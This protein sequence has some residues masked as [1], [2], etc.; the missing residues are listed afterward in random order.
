GRCGRRA[1]TIRFAPPSHLPWGLPVA[2]AKATGPLAGANLETVFLWARDFDR[3]KSFYRDT[4]GLSVEYENPH[5][6]ALH[7]GRCSIA[8]HL[9]WEAHPRSDSW[10]MEF[11]VE[12]IAG[13][14]ADLA[15]RGVR[16][17]P[18]RDERLGRTA[19]LRHPYG[20]VI[21]L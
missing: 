18:I 4:L 13:V 2:R 8:L 15:T 6:A 9:E 20:Q 14:V 10:H 17:A 11:L 12:D 16:V 1:R 21:W 3:M 19:T 7:A 5:F